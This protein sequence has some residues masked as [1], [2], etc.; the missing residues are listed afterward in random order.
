MKKEKELNRK[1]TRLIFIIIV[2]IA[3]STLFVSK[4][5]AQSLPF[6]GKTKNKTVKRMKKRQ[7]RKSQKGKT[8]YYRT[9]SGKLKKRRL[10]TLNEKKF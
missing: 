10:I 4:C 5:E 3:L 6:A 1:A 8:Y 9:K 2:A 7:V